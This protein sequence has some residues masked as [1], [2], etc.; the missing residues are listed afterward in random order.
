MNEIDES[1]RPATEDEQ[2]L[3]PHAAAALF[4]ET[5]RQ[6]QRDF[7]MQP[8]LLTAIRAA[9]ALLGYGGLWLSVHGQHPYTGPNTGAILGLYA[10]IVIV[11][12]VSV[13]VLQRASEGVSGPSQRQLRT[14]AAAY[15]TA[16]IATSVFQGA[17]YHDGVSHAIVYGVFPAAAPLLVVGACLG[18][19]AA[20]QDNWRLLAVAIAVVGLGT[21]SAYAGPRNVWG[22]IAV[23][24]CVM[25]VAYA[26]AQ[27]WD[28][29]RSMR[30]PA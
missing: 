5:T 22:V 6:A 12:V 21:G 1:Q 25:L 14:L 2:P 4:E 18:G 13:R 28:R 9:V 30:L 16:W 23:G 10:G 20:A 17:L 29:H 11:L 7:S 19:M 27:L 24:G 3:D 15:A 26:V 8:P